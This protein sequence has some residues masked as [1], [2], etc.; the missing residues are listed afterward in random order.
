MKIMVADD[1]RV[2]IHL[3]ASRLRA[4]GFEVV[5][6]F[7]VMQAWMVVM[8]AQP[9]AIVLDISMPAGTGFEFLK[10][11]RMSTKTSHI[12]VVVAS[13]SVDP[14]ARESVIQAGADEFM[15]KPLDFDQ[16]HK[17]LCRLLGMPV[18]GN[19]RELRVTEP[20]L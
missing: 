16:L 18:G 8:R 3:V 11:L 9:D 17:S 19:S 12:P 15:P 13:G 20:V 2:H 4:K 10:R 5:T 7:D 14:S 1:D 6:A